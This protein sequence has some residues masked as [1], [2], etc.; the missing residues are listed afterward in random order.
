M[1]LTTEGKNLALNALGSAGIKMALYNSSDVELTGGSPAYA[2]K[3]IT[4][5]TASGGAITMNGTDPVFDVPAGAS[6]KYIK[7]L[8]NAGTTVLD[9][10]TLA[11]AET[12]AT[13]GTYT[14]TD[15]TINLNK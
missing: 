5:G 13:Q 10:Y 12:F 7:V 11:T 6:V 3:P 8:D 4:W 15:A 9:I 2:R 14:V 1:A